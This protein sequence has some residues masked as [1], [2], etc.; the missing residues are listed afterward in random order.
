MDN[1]DTGY[2]LNKQNITLQRV[3][4]SQMCALLGIKAQYR[5][6]RE[7]KTYNGY[8]ELETFY[9]EPEEVWCIFDEHPNQKSMKKMGWNAELQENPIIIHVHYNLKGLQV[10]ALFTI[11]AGLDNAEPRTFRVIQLSNIAVYPVNISC[12][13]AL[14]WENSQPKSEVVNFKNSNFNVL[15]DPPEA[16]NFI[17]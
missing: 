17:T 4:F 14:E 8:G 13:L 2:L 16:T 5:A 10:G 1:R 15:A 9:Y 3:Y 12:E 7:G 11:P 6:P